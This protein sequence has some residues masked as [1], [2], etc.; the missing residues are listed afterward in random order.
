MVRH[1]FWHVSIDQKAVDHARR[2][3]RVGMREAAE[4]RIRRSVGPALPPFDGRQT[5]K[6]ENA[7]YYAQHATA[8]CCRKCIEEWHGIPQ[9]VQLTEDQI[10]Y[11][12]QLATMYID[13]RL[14]FLTEHGETIPR[15]RR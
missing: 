7:I 11:L 10:Q 3:G 14:P 4:N 5:P 6:E 1:Y 15:K 8:S 13:E 12:T 9:G 2:K